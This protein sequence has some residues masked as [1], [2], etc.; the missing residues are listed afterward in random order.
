MKWSGDNEA[1]SWNPWLIMPVDG[2]L[3][4]GQIGPVLFREVEWVEIDSH[5]MNEGGR[6]VPTD[7]SDK[8]V[9]ALRAA[10]IDYV[11]TDAV[12]CITANAR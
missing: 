8:L 5:Q 10:S 7:Q 4:T 12:F 3:E 11:K 1:S 6:L 9:R 2:M